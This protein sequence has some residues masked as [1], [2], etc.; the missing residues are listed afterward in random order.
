VA[1]EPQLND[2]GASRLGA[3]PTR[4]SL[5]MVG[6]IAAVSAATVVGARA[7]PSRG[8]DSLADAPFCGHRPV[9]ADDATG[10][11]TKLK[12]AWNGTAICTSAAPVAK[13]RGF[14]AA[15][16][17]DVDFIDFGGSTEQLLE[18][19]ATGK[20]DA[21][22]GMALRWL[23]PLEQ[24]FDV[25]ITAGVHG[26]CMR[27]IGSN[28][29]GTG[30]LES[31]KGKTIAVSDL[32]APEKNF[33]AIMLAQ[34]GIDPTKTSRGANIL[35]R[36][37]RWPS[38]R[39]RRRRSPTAIRAPT[40]GSRSRSSSRSRTTCPARLPRGLAAFWRCAAASCGRTR[41]WRAG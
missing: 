18:A 12:L 7:V 34:T 35:R 21:G 17:L 23:K 20:A 32:A 9:L 28:A 13:E 15:H 1:E 22:I 30:T 36:S 26:G 10:P 8:V 25:K 40:S 41:R 38:P 4:R 29:A 19:I 33:F 2:A 39:A 6:G 37:C 5:L 14:F 16:G 24:G 31:L 27:L 3:F 11:V